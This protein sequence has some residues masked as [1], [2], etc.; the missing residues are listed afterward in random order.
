MHYL[1]LNLNYLSSILLSFLTELVTTL[2]WYV[3]R[4]LQKKNKLKVNKALYTFSDD[5]THFYNI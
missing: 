1:A 3:F 4:Q 5:S 2:I